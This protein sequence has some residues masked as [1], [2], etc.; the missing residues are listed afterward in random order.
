MTHGIRYKCKYAK[1]NVVQEEK[2]K[3]NETEKHLKLFSICLFII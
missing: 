1:G 2:K 3:K